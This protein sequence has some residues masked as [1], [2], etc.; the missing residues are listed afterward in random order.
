MLREL[1]SDGGD[2]RITEFMGLG[3]PLGI[4]LSIPSLRQHLSVIL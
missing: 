1:I 4:I 3:L 2:H